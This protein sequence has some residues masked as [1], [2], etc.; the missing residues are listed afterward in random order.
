M[1]DSKIKVLQMVAHY[2]SVKA[3]A[4]ALSYTPSAVSYQ[5]KQ[6]SEQVGAKLVEPSGRGIILTGA[7]R[8]LMRHA[9][10]MQK[11]W[12]TARSE[13]ASQSEEFSGEFR[14]CGFSTAA[15]HLLPHALAVLHD[16]HTNLKVRLVEAEPVQCFELL[17]SEEVDLALVMV[18]AETP[19]LSDPR[20]DQ[21]LVVDDPLDLVVAST[22]P[23]AVH[24]VLPLSAAALEPWVIAAPGSAYY[25]LTVSACMSAGFTPDVAHQADEWETGAALVSE[26]LCVMLMPRLGRINSEWP[27]R[28][29]RLSGDPAPSRRIMA[30]TRKGGSGHPLVAQ[31]LQLVKE[32][33][34]KLFVREEPS[35]ITRGALGDKN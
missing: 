27:V 15:S 21:Q 18:T 13:I 23:L 14:L 9:E 29:I 10:I 25:K 11:Q 22:H 20:F 3:A 30:V 4:N 31:T 24:D 16:K 19:P 7:A 34:A 8:T 32:T 6:L 28:R 17:L 35:R 1:I 2:G 33:S 26:R 5:L 12:E